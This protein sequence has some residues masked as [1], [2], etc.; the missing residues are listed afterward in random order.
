MYPVPLSWE[1]VRWGLGK[2][3]S[4]LKS[5]GTSMNPIDREIVVTAQVFLRQLTDLQLQSQDPKKA[6]LLG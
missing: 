4:C 5:H 6:V 3:A 2:R 1:V